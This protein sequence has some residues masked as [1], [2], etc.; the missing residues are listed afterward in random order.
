MAIQRII[1]HSFIVIVC[2]LGA[3]L[4]AY[5]LALSESRRIQSSSL[6]LI[7]LDLARRNDET[8]SQ[9][10]RAVS[11]LNSG[12]YGPPGS[13]EEIARMRYL[14]LSS[15]YLQAVGRVSGTKLTITSMGVMRPPVD[16]G[17]PDLISVEGAKIWLDTSLEF[18]GGARFHASE[19]NGVIC[20]LAPRLM[21]DVYTEERDVSMAVIAVTS[22][23]PLTV[24]GSVRS[25]WLAYLG[26]RDHVVVEKD[27]MLIALQ[28]SHRVDVIAVAAQPIGVVDRRTT[29]LSGVFLPIGIAIGSALAILLSARIRRQSEFPHLLREAIRCRR[30]FLEFQPVVDMTTGAIVGA[31]ALVR[32]RRPTGEVTGPNVFIR[33]AEE[34]GIMEEI[35]NQVID[36]AFLA[37]R[38]LQKVGRDL[39][40]GINLTSADVKSGRIPA[41]LRNYSEAYSVDLR[42]V[43]VEIT[44]TGLLSGAEDMRHLA[45]LRETGVKIA[46]DDFGTGYSSLA[47]L[48]NLDVD[49]LKIDKLFVEAIGTEAATA[50]VVYHMIHMARELKM[51]IIAEGIET[52][53]QARILRELDVRFGQGYLF[54]KPM[55]ES[56][57]ASL[58]AAREPSYGAGNAG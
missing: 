25:D 7:A 45:D 56:Q 49:V 5:R 20:F 42:K 21:F 3:G 1:G 16:L 40:M 55:S 13:P 9:T 24:W 15:T 39:Y 4:L 48:M 46:M 11:E 32:W 6:A 10:A 30:F 2:I 54:G 29:L 57:F 35:T 27:G 17:P 28:R 23:R 47:Y 18:A 52:D 33:V 12:Q 44:E 41:L 37:L 38:D 53:E 19:R 50:N 26:N 58:V 34:V 31:E 8:I 51:E 36:M 22:R 43:S 14:S